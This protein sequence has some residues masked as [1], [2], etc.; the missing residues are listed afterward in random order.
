MTDK[1]NTVSSTSLPH[2]CDDFL[3]FLLC[4]PDLLSPVEELENEYH[5]DIEVASLVD[6]D[7]LNKRTSSVSLEGSS[8]IT[9]RDSK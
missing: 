7:R 4:P 3:F 9:S 8:S 5:R 2:P 6:S 1:V